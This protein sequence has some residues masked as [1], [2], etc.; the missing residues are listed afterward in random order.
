[1]GSLPGQN[2]FLSADEKLH[3]GVPCRQPASQQRSM[4]GAGRPAHPVPIQEVMAS[5]W[6]GGGRVALLVRID[7]RL[8]RRAKQAA[9]D[10]EISLARYV[11]RAIG[12]ELD[13]LPPGKIVARAIRAASRT[14][15]PSDVLWTLQRP[16][17]RNDEGADARD[18]VEWR[19]R[20]RSLRTE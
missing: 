7:Q 15:S 9:R 14:P 20:S 5:E 1:M 3:E 6:T 4:T 19:S 11:E 10:R 17:T 2:G 13:Y 16:R 8:H 18:T 12:R